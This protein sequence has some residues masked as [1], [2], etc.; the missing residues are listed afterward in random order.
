MSVLSSGVAADSNLVYYQDV[1]VK[2]EGMTTTIDALFDGTVLRFDS[3]LPF[4][5]NTRVRVIIMQL[6]ASDSP[7]TSFLHTAQALAL[8]APADFAMNIE[9]YLYDET[10]Y[11]AS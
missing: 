3:P 5:P 8:D 7:V 2:E 11:A 9:T 1:S 10:A 6:E 4:P